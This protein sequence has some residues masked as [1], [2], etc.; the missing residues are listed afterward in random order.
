MDISFPAEALGWRDGETGG[1]LFGRRGSGG[2]DCLGA[3]VGVVVGGDVIEL[4][5]TCGGF[6]SSPAFLLGVFEKDRRHLK[7]NLEG[8]ADSL[9][10]VKGDCA[11]M[12]LEI[13]LLIAV[14]D[15]QFNLE[16]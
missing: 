3:G 7:G 16:L 8:G 14:M 9:K 4:S 15:V 1:A 2:A 12:R 6:A 5:G 10:A 11:N 13:V